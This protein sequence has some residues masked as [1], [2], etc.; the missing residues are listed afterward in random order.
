M[1]NDF[2][3]KPPEEVFNELVTFLKKD[4]RRSFKMEKKKKK[5]SK[6]MP[7]F[8]AQKPIAAVLILLVFIVGFLEG[9]FH[10]QDL[11]QAAK[12]FV[13]QSILQRGSEPQIQVPQFPGP[14]TPQ[15]SQEEAM[16]K[17]VR[18]VSPAV[19]SIVITKDIPV[20][21]TYYENPFGDIFGD[22]LPFEIEV[23]M[24]RQKGT[25]KKKVGGGTGFI[26]SAD[27]MIL[28]NKHVV[29]EEKADYTVITNENK[30]YPA[31]VLA[32]DPFQDLAILQ[33]ENDKKITGQGDI[34]ETP[35]PVV[36]LGDSSN[37]QIGQTVIAI[38]NALGEFRNT[39]SAGVISGLGRNVTASGGGFVETLEDVIQTDAGINKGNSGGPLLNL[40]GEV[41][42]VNVAMAES[43]QSISFAIPINKAK[44]DIRQVKTMGK[45]VYPFLGVRY[46]SITAEVQEEKG[47]SVDY[48]ALLVP[49]DN[50]DEPAVVSGTAAA[51]AG[52][53]EGDIILEIDGIKINQDNLL[54]NLVRAHVP[55]DKIMLK[56][57]R[58]KKELTLELILGEKT[59]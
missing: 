41:I 25:E 8:M 46:V 26:I 43:A 3:I 39:V 50:P 4:V 17:V 51:K 58:G 1:A 55:G 7:S 42:G 15:T 29:S 34:A 13:T 31:R 28:T 40:K 47:L 45:I 9:S 53:K 30:R 48:G 5:Q 38:G 10:G 57:L 44:R 35:F 49:G 11:Y 2:K 18:E 20:Y 16:I 22:D 27:G 19:V 54:S 24:Y 33:I 12:G 37:L 52:L 59:S 23:P 21:E 36:R 14:Y 56:V 6:K 32:L